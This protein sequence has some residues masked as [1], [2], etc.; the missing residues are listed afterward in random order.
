[1]ALLIAKDGN[2]DRHCCKPL[3]Y[4]DTPP[5]LSYLLTMSQVGGHEFHSGVNCRDAQENAQ[6]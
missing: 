4:P 3:V 1:M 6:C 5:L 2:V